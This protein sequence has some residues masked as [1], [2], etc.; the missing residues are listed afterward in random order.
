MDAWNKA[1]NG[2]GYG[3]KRKM[4]NKTNNFFKKE[5]LK[6]VLTWYKPMAW[7]ERNIREETMT[8]FGCRVKVSETDGST[9]K[10]YFPSYDQS[11]KLVGFKV[12]DITKAGEKEE[13]YTIGKVI[14]KNQLFGQKQ[15]RPNAKYLTITEGESCCMSAWQSIMDYFKKRFPDNYNENISPA[16]VTFSAGTVQA[17]NH[18]SHN[19]KFLSKFQEFR[20]AFDNDYVTE[21]EKLTSNNHIVRG[22]EAIEDV[23]CYLLSNESSQ[24][25]REV[26][27]VKIED[28]YGDCSDYVQD[29]NGIKLAENI[30]EKKK[31]DVFSAGKIITVEDMTVEEL[32]K[33]KEKGILIDTFPLLMDKVWGLRKGELWVLTAMSGT[34]KCEAK[35]TP[36]IMHDGSIKNIE[37]VKKGDKVLGIDGSPRNVFYTHSG[38]DKMYKVKQKSGEDYT[39]NSRHILSLYPTINNKKRGWKKGV[40]INISIPDYLKIPKRT[41]EFLKGWC[42]GEMSFKNSVPVFEPW[43]VGN[44]L[45]DGGLDKGSVS[46]SINDTEIID[47]W[48]NISHRNNFGFSIYHYSK[49]DNLSRTLNINGLSYKLKEIGIYSNKR[50]PQQYKFASINDR[51]EL[52]SGL[53]DGDGYLTNNCYEIYFKSIDLCNDIAFVARSLGFKVTVTEKFS[54]CQS[55]DGAIYHKMFISGDIEELKLRLKRKQGEKRKQIKNHL[56]TGITVEEE[57]VNEFFGFCIDGDH[58]YLHKDFTVTHNTVTFSEIAYKTAEASNEKVALVFLEENANETLMRMIA[59]RLQVNYY[60]FIF[61]PL[62]YC[63]KEQFQ[64]AYEWVKDKFVFLNVFGSMSVNDIMNHFKSLFYVSG[65][66]YIFFDHI[67]VLAADPSVNDERRMLDDFMT[68]LATWV[69][70]T[71]VCVL[72]ISHLSRLAQQEM[73]KISELKEAKWINCRKEHLRGS[74]S[75]EQMAW[76]VLGLDMLLQPNRE[77][78]DVRLT[79][80]KNRPI[81][82]LGTTDQFHLNQDTGLIELT[83][84]NLGY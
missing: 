29:N 60:R 35:G 18:I 77:R 38:F 39:V 75:L 58:L 4:T 41:R 64:E 16:V 49:R 37:D 45:A 27:V 2:C 25:K 33:P 12:K 21:L 69:A 32:L 59:R 79:V 11:G 20:L 26:F 65:C 51:R 70:Q 68:K 57:G 8:H 80:L 10:V 30:V 40:P 43:A 17:V 53:L 73:G 50:V 66:S 52:L 28:P 62:K 36:I 76:V 63:T 34:G 82:F 3:E 31:L 15:A 55:F 6:E 61:D 44:W 22:S 48:N 13:Y 84:C 56:L 72:T 71:P 19:E 81:G 74:A 47:E 5:T 46:V 42:P 9:E 23:G 14:K 83:N 67:T 54:K 7:P 78:S 1:I 24:G